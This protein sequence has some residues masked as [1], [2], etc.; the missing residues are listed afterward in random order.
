MKRKK[1]RRKGAEEIIKIVWM[2]KGDVLHKNNL[3]LP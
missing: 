1:E 3:N 2:D